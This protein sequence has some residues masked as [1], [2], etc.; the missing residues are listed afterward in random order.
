MLG[1][2]R[3]GYSLA[4][5]RQIPSRSGRLHPTL[6]HAVRGDRASARSLAVALLIPPDLEFLAGIYA[7]GAT[8]A[9]TLVTVGVC[10]LR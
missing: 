1:L 8:L 4:I 9:F 2:S 3:L 10:V 5:N 7:F 6:L